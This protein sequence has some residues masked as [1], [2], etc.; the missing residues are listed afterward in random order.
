MKVGEEFTI[1]HRD[2]R[3]VHIKL[4]AIGNTSDEGFKRVFF[5]VN[6]I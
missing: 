2:N 1:M 6:H 4:V 3:E 5:E